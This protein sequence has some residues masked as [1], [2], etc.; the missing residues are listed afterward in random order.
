VLAETMA[1]SSSSSLSLLTNILSQDLVVQAL[2]QVNPMVKFAS[3]LSYQQNGMG[4]P[5][6]GFFSNYHPKNLLTINK[7]IQRNHVM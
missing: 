1:S 3:R 6:I 7:W 4:V 5:H 2:T